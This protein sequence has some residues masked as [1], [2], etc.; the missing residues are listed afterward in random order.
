[1]IKRK[2]RWDK[3]TTIII[4]FI[5][6]IIIEET[7]VLGVKRYVNGPFKIELLAKKW[8]RTHKQEKEYKAS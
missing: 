4:V 8:Y 2:R 5:L 6:L 3:M 1:M 7:I